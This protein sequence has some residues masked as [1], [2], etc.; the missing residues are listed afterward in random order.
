MA[1]AALFAGSAQGQVVPGGETLD[2][3]LPQIRVQH[4][5]RLSDAT[6]WTS[7]DGRTY[8]RIKWMTPQGRILFFDAE[9]FMGRYKEVS[10]H[11]LP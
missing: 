7:P 9:S 6:R 10:V 4:P 2:R 11:E 8:Y 3:I 5:G 1:M